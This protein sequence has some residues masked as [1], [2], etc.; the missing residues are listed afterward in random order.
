[1]SAQVIFKF[2]LSAAVITLVSEVSKRNN[3]LAA[4]LGSLPWTTLMILIWMHLEKAPE[5]KVGAHSFYTFWYVIPTL[6][7]FLA[8]P[9]LLKRGI[10]FW[11]TI[12]IYVA[13]T[14]GLFLLMQ[15]IAAQFGMKL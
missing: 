15:K 4:L 3:A 5:A 12:G 10:G 1:M 11:P 8:I 7:M 13:G 6:P 14:Y 9:W 2:L